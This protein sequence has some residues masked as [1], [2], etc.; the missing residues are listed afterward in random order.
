MLVLAH[1]CGECAWALD[2]NLVALD[3]RVNSALARQ[4]GLSG[5]GC[6]VILPHAANSRRA[7]IANFKRGWLVAQN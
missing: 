1:V 4:E 3:V 2:V 6:A 5:H 7:E